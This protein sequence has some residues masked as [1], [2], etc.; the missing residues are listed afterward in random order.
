MIVARS[1][2]LL[3][4]SAALATVLTPAQASTYGREGGD[5]F[6]RLA[7]WYAGGNPSYV[8]GPGPYFGY[9]GPS[10]WD[11]ATIRR[12]RHRHVRP[13]RVRG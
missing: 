13:L 11:S 8:P 4:A 7:C 3:A 10:C 6:A 1:L 9:G 2:L 12:Y 5:A